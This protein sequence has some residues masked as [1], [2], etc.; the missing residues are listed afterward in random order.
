[1]PAMK[2]PACPKP[3]LKKGLPTDV[4]NNL[5][6]NEWILVGSYEGWTVNSVIST[7]FLLHTVYNST[8]HYLYNET[9][10]ALNS[11]KSNSTLDQTVKRYI[12][13]I[14]NYYD[15][16]EIKVYFLKKYEEKERQSRFQNSEQV[17]QEEVHIAS[18]EVISDNLAESS[19]KRKAKE[20][21]A[22]TVN[23]RTFTMQNPEY[24]VSPNTPIIDDNNLQL[25]LKKTDLC[26]SSNITL[27]SEGTRQEYTEINN[28]H[29]SNVSLKSIPGAMDLYR[30]I[31]SLDNNDFDEKIT[32]L[33]YQKNLFNK[34]IKFACIDFAI[35]CQRITPTPINDERTILFENVLPLFKY[36]GNITNAI[37]FRWSEKKNKE[38]ATV[39]F[40]INKNKGD[41]RLADGIGSYLN[42]T[43]CMA[44][45]SS[46]YGQTQNIVHTQEDSIKNIVHGIDMILSIMCT[47]NKASFSTMKKI[48]A[49]SIHVI[50]KKMTLTRYSLKNRKSWQ[51]VEC[52]SAEVPLVYDDKKKMLKVLN[53]FAFIYNEIQV[54][55]DLMEK[56]EDEHLGLIEV[57]TC[58]M[59]GSLED[60]DDLL[61]SL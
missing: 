22:L 54:Q 56:L 26:F 60:C 50:Q 31:M 33:P 59:I 42:G 47:F 45:E 12:T 57:K 2:F 40:Y 51:V 46:G 41:L 23:K 16:I 28:N 32:A 24:I 61:L 4:K 35:N 25:I 53:L 20:P 17:L 36:F 1:M 3:L 15:T 30:E 39:V 18:N 52:G 43:S 37:S 44:I 9:L 55:K 34:F 6:V 27:A 5:N 10:Q 19:R 11:L 7:Y 58:A 13:K 48:H 21:T 38:A 49:Y 29:D 8:G 14:Y